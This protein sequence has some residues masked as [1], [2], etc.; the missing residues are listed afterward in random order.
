MLYWYSTKP[1]ALQLE[2]VSGMES[3][4]YWSSCSNHYPGFSPVCI[5]LWLQYMHETK[6]VELES[7][8]HGLK[9]A[10]E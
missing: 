6:S 2:A 9:Q 8:R 10:F 3:I 4:F 1:Y 5:V 7:H